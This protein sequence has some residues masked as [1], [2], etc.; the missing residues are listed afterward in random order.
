M[1]KG[2]YYHNKESIASDF[3]LSFMSSTEYII[4]TPVGVMR[5]VKVIFRRGGMSV[6]HINI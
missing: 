2:L 1:S 6:I 4:Q 5:N 3:I